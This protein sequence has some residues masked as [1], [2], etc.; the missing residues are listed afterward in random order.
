VSLVPLRYKPL[1]LSEFFKS[2]AR[3]QAL[4]ESRAG[5]LLENFA[6]ALSEAGYATITAR[7][8]LRAAEHFIRWTNWH[9]IP[10]CKWNEQSLAQFER[11]LARCHCLHYAHVSHVIRLRVTHGARLF[12]SYLRDA[13]II[14]LPSAELSVHDPALL[15]AFCQWMHQQR[16]VSLA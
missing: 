11:H 10:T 15:Q 8:H 6:R 1:M 7:H 14:T 4:R 2:R 5:S 13:R 9:G 16:P 3:I 12:L